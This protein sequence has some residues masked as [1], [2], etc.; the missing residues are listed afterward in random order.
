MIVPSSGAMDGRC[1][2]SRLSVRVCLPFSSQGPAGLLTLSWPTGRA[3]SLESGLNVISV[4]RIECVI[5]TVVGSRMAEL[6]LHDL[7]SVSLMCYHSQ[8]LA[9]CTAPARSSLIC[10]ELDDLTIDQASLSAYQTRCV[11]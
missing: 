9:V 2:N 10:A 7:F 3:C 5:S 4:V 6:W 8:V 1:A 11:H